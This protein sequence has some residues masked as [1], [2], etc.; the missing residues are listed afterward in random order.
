MGDKHRP[1]ADGARSRK[2]C[3]V[4]KGNKVGYPLDERTTNVIRFSCANMMVSAIIRYACPSW[5]LQP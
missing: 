2:M 5:A 1:V 3:A 4:A